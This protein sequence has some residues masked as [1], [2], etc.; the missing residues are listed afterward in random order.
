MYEDD[1]ILLS[2]IMMINNEDKQ[3]Q[4]LLE[5]CDRYAENGIY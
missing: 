1:I 3:L 5:N 4:K 2:P